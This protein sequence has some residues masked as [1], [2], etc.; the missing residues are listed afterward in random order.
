[1]IGVVSPD[2]VSRMFASILDTGRLT[3]IILATFSW[4]CQQAERSAQRRAE[5]SAEQGKKDIGEDVQRDSSCVNNRLVSSPSNA[6]GAPAVGITAAVSDDQA[7]G[8]VNGD[9]L[10]S[11][12]TS[13][14]SDRAVI[15]ETPAIR[16]SGYR[17]PPSVLYLSEEEV[18]CPFSSAEP[19]KREGINELD[20]PEERLASGSDLSNCGTDGGAPEIGSDDEAPEVISVH[21]KPTSDSNTS[22]ASQIPQ[23]PVLRFL[24]DCV[25]DNANEFVERSIFRRVSNS[26]LQSLPLK[27]S[28]ECR[29]PHERTTYFGPSCQAVQK[30]LPAG[31]TFS[32]YQG[33]DFTTHETNLA[34]DSKATSLA[35]EAVAE[36]DPAS[37]GGDLQSRSFDSEVNNSPNASG[38]GSPILTDREDPVK[39]DK[40]SGERKSPLLE[41][42]C[43]SFEDRR[44]IIEKEKTRIE[45]PGKSQEIAIAP[46]TAERQIA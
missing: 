41:R 38:R 9:Q 20:I 11:I 27:S 23:H 45:V 1:M 40:G 39:S 13:D 5:A 35:P 18:E 46:Y 21:Q 22:S 6:H 24:G 3:H 43:L 4:R 37:F 25:S 2:R 7:Q 14:I 8:I 36:H 29:R 15:P 28:N 16:L 44:D 33:E 17:V 19:F 32:A 12:I 30:I 42:G 34:N 31:V 10:P 26:E